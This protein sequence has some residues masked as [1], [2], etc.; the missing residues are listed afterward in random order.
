MWGK[1]RQPPMGHKEF[2][3]LLDSEGRVV[4]S[5]ALRE[6]VFYG[7]IEHQLRREVNF[8]FHMKF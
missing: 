8:I 5:K 6:R 3:A 1:P 7:G 4:E 2:T